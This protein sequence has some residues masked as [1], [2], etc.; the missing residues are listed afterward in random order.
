MWLE[1]KN[2]LGK[3]SV[4]LLYTNYKLAQKETKE[5]TPLTIATNNIKYLRVTL[6]KQVK[7]PYNKNFS[8]RRKKLKKIS[9]DRNI[10]CL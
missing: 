2:K 6:T 10:P 3:K 9:E 1:K 4:A 7:D 8:L 5:T